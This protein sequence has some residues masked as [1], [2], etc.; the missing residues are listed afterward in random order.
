LKR[1]LVGVAAQIVHDIVRVRFSQATDPAT[2]EAL[3]VLRRWFRQDEWEE[4]AEMPAV[5]AIADDCIEA[6]TLLSKAGVTDDRLRTSLA[7]TLGSDRESEL[8]LKRLAEQLSG[9]SPDVR[10]WLA[11][12]DARPEMDLMA[13]SAARNLDAV[14]ADVLVRRDQFDRLSSGPESVTLVGLL[15]DSFL[16]MARARSLELAYSPGETVDYSPLDHELIGGARQG[17]RRVVVVEPQVRA[18]HS[19]G[20]HRVVRKALV[21]AEGG[22]VGDDER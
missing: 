20:D 5:R 12:T 13:E 7:L 21:R 10:R 3:D 22:K 19:S 9:L 8:L 18:R 14:I 11:R 4:L 17:V 1:D 6:I 15:V 16:E 2:Y